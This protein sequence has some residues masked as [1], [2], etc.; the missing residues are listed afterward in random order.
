MGTRFEQAEAHFVY[1]GWRLDGD[2]EVC[3]RADTRRGEPAAAK[4]RDSKRSSLEQRIGRD[5]DRV[6]H[7]FRI[8]KGDDAG[9]WTGHGSSIGECKANTSA[10]MRS[11]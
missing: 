7:P 1:S 11:R 5:L 2:P 6:R 3:G 8:G 10:L 4:F 9:T